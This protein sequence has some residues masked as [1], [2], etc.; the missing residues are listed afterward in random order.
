MN[1]LFSTNIRAVFGLFHMRFLYLCCCL[2]CLFSL[3]WSGRDCL[4]K[5]HITCSSIRGLTT[6]ESKFVDSRGF[7]VNET[8]TE[9]YYWMLQI[10][11]QGH[12]AKSGPSQLSDVCY[13]CVIKHKLFTQN[14][15]FLCL[16]RD[17]KFG[18]HFLGFHQLQDWKVITIQYSRC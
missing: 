13:L 16:H 6:F 10:L 2:F 9:H 4:E 18:V 8:I 3:L 1:A 14:L 11:L 17:G 12:Q 5:D 15:L 7:D